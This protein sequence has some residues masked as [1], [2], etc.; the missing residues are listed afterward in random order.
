[1][2]IGGN[3]LSP[4]YEK[5]WK[6]RSLYM[7]LEITEDGGFSLTAHTGAAEKKYEYFLDPGEMKYY[8]KEDRSDKG[9]SISIEN[10]VLTEETEDHLMVYELAYEREFAPA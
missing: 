7:F 9:T 8:L 3:D 4:A 1:M 10:R 6:D 2:V 5:G